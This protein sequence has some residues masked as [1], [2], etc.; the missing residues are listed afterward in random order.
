MNFDE[1]KK[2]YNEKLD[3]VGTPEEARPD[4]EELAKIY[5]GL[6]IFSEYNAEEMQ[7]AQQKAREQ[8]EKSNKIVGIDK[9]IILPKG[10]IH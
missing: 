3:K 6:V 8:M 9:K 5:V 1:F 7:K 10:G 2:R 4:S